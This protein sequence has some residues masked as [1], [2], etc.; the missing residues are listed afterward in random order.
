MKPSCHRIQLNSIWTKR[1]VSLLSIRWH[2]FFIRFFL[3]FL[4]LTKTSFAFRKFAQIW[5]FLASLQE[6]SD[7]VVNFCCVAQIPYSISIDWNDLYF[8]FSIILSTYIDFVSNISI[9]KMWEFS[10][11]S[12]ISQLKVDQAYLNVTS[13]LDKNVWLYQLSDECV[14]V[15]LQL[16]LVNIC[17]S[18]SLFNHINLTL[19]WF[20]A[21]PL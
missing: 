6:I 4:F 12:M 8:I 20:C 13:S 16:I 9:D 11:D 7:E 10:Q 15:I 17:G 1:V 14:Q 21:V 3:S 2:N 18:T 5:F 19:F